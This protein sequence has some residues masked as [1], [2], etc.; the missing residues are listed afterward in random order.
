MKV[1]V[2]YEDGNVFQ[3]FGRTQSFKIYEVEDKQIVSSEVI[4]NDGAGHEALADVL[5]TRGIDV[6]ICGGL[7]EGAK[8]ALAAVGVEVIS[9]AQGDADEAVRAYLNGTLE[10]QGVN[11]DHHDHEENH[12]CG[13]DCGSDCGS[14]CGGCPNHM[15]A[16]EGPNVG[17]LCKV[18]YKGTF[19]D[20][21]QFDSSYDRGEPLEFICGVGQMIHGFDKAVAVMAVGDTV[22]VHLMPAEAY[23]E[24]NP[25]LLI[26]AEISKMRGSEKLNVGDQV[27]LRNPRGQ[28]FPVTVTEKTDTTITFD[29]N[30]EMAGKELNFQIELVSAE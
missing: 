16:I 17:K 27:A 25:D 2:T 15:P 30:H 9:G 22:N 11:C 29:A 5:R 3:H 14:D 12:G 21:A 26:T 10:S 24:Y 4:G 18:H 8:A 6:L 20:G 7:G 28:R 23:G 19:N 1:A 13:E